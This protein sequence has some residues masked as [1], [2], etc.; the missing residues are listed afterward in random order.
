M[1]DNRIAFIGRIIQINPTEFR[2]IYNLVSD[3]K[4]EDLGDNLDREG[5][6]DAQIDIFIGAKYQIYLHMLN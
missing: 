3:K 1:D 5:F 4:I 6:E 2:S